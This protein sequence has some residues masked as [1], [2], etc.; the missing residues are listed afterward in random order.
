MSNNLSG[1]Y[2]RS[3]GMALQIGV[4]NLGG[5][6]A[7]NFYR[8]KDGPRYILGHALELGFIGAGIVAALTLV[9]GYSAINRKRERQINEGALDRYTSEELSA[10]GD[11]AITFRYIY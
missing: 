2:K 7:S 4:G 6:M 1:S 3:A 8:Q 11:K 9:L 10:Q 5:A